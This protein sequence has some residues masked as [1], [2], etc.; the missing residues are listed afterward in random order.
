MFGLIIVNPGACTY[1]NFAFE[2]NIK[3][4]KAQVK[5]TSIW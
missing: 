4:L 3:N 5:T 1:P 2:F